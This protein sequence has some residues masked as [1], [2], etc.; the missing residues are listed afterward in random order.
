MKDAQTIELLVQT[1]S[2]VFFTLEHIGSVVYCTVGIKV[3]C[4]LYTFM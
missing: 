1:D 2:G 4:T 3:K